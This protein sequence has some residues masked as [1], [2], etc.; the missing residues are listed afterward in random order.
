MNAAGNQVPQGETPKKKYRGCL[1]LLLIPTLLLLLAAV[2][3]LGIP[4]RWQVEPKISRQ[5]ATHLQA[6]LQKLT[7]A[8][9][10]E[11]G[12]M[13]QT[14]EIEL[15]P[16]EINTLLTA[17]LRAAQLRP[18]PGLYYDAEWKQGALRLRICRILPL[19][20]VNLEAELIP[21]VNSGKAELKTR[22]C[23]IGRLP[24]SRELVD[25]AL[26][27]AL[28]KNED[29]LEFRVILELVEAL[30][31]QNGSIRLRI[32]PQKINLIFPLLLYAASGKR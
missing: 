9:V 11:D 10:T 12:K 16:A 4:R 23:R 6:I 20:A 2:L 31:V 26:L 28:K 13:A 29:R 25:R 1:I 5:E 32:R 7:S 22:F 3:V 15:N 8:M 24:L 27:Q 18:T 17:G 19:L 21:S 30:A 14:A